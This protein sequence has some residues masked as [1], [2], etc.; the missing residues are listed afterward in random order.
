MRQGALQLVQF[1][2]NDDLAVAGAPVAGEVIMVINL[3][4]VKVAGRFD[5]GDDGGGVIAAGVQLLDEGQCCQLLAVAVRINGRAVLR[6]YIMTLPVWRG[7]VVR[8]EEYLQ[9]GGIADGVGL[10][11]QLDGFGVA[12]VATAHAFVVRVGQVAIYIAGYHGGDALQLAE[13]GFGAP[14]TSAC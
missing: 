4:R 3:G 1:G 11:V 6:A 13:H 2:R 5:V 9:Q 10:V 8:Q 12:A 7:G 14:E